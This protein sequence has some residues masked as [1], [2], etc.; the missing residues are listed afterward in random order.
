MAEKTEISWTDATFNIAWG[1]QKVSPAC[2]HCYAE[3]WARRYGVGWGPKAE[4]R[5]FG[6]K[7]WQEPLKWN[8]KAEREGRRLRVFCSSMCDVFED[9]ETVAGE[10]VKLWPLIRST[11]NLD[12]LLLTKRAERIKE[13][14]PDD[15]G[16]GYLNVWLGVTAENQEWADKRIPHLLNVPAAVRF[17]SCEPLLGRL[18]L[19]HLRYR[20]CADDSPI[21]P[22]GGC[23]E[24]YDALK[25][26]AI[27]GRVGYNCGRLSWVIVGGESGP[28]ARPMNPAWARSLRDQCVAAGVAFHFKQWGCLLPYGQGKIPIGSLVNPS[29]NRIQAHD[30]VFTRMDKHEA[31]R[32]LDG[33]E[34]NDLPR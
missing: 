21:Q 29:R 14:L 18:D 16:A 19:R 2:E 3:T 28:H 30:H 32:L 7:H 1:C 25:G 11:P 9:H 5:T 12:W 20:V 13:C 34:W 8:R 24:D 23:V 15:W 33:R 17:V 6:E 4:R 27:I 22:V 26:E 31:G 10:L